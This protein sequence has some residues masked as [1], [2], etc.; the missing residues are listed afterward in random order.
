MYRKSVV[1]VL[2][3]SIQFNH[4]TEIPSQDLTIVGEGD[5]D[6]ALNI[7]TLTE[8]GSPQNQGGDP[9]GQ[10][11]EK[12][13]LVMTGKLYNLSDAG[14]GDNSKLIITESPNELLLP[15][16]P[17]RN[18]FGRTER[19]KGLPGCYLVYGDVPNQNWSKAIFI[20][21]EFGNPVELLQKIVQHRLMKKSVMKKEIVYRLITD[22]S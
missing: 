17:R 11:L 19:L 4:K 3:M 20:G 8:Q 12:M 22:E 5:T 1:Q 9:E 6:K 7:I 2:R 14:L 13:E 16:L 15:T 10:I 18:L 21:T